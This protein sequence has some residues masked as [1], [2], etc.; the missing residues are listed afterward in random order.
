MF[1]AAPWRHRHIRFIPSTATH[2]HHHGRDGKRKRGSALLPAAS[3]P[4]QQPERRRSTM[5]WQRELPEHGAACRCTAGNGPAAMQAVCRGAA[6]LQTHQNAS[7]L[8]AA[9]TTWRTG[10]GGKEAFVRATGRRCRPPDEIS[11]ECALRF[12]PIDHHRPQ[13]RSSAFHQQPHASS[14]SVA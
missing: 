13:L 1:V 2:R 7:E 12:M 5:Q 14:S 4:A 6:S 10:T 9:Q 3:L 8:T 11:A